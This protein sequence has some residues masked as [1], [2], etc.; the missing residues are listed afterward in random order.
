MR[1]LQKPPA[2]S[3]LAMACSA[4]FLPTITAVNN[5]I[6]KSIL[7]GFMD[8]YPGWQEFLGLGSE[9]LSA[10]HHDAVHAHIMIF[11]G[12]EDLSTSS[13]I[14]NE[15]SDQTFPCTYLAKHVW[16]NIP[17]YVITS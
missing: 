10:S 13:P 1:L 16:F 6:T 12:S 4:P 17:T 2:G 9:G 14:A 3:F 11:R 15:E 8:R 7:R 5:R